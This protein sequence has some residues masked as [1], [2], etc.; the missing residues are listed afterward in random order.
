METGKVATAATASLV[1]IFSPVWLL[2]AIIAVFIIIDFVIG[3]IVSIRIKKQGFI[4]EKAYKT[5][6]KLGGA[7]IVIILSHLLDTVVIPVID[8][9]LANI[10]TGIFCGFEL[11]SILSN[12]A[13]LSNHPVF[14]IIKKWAKSE[15]ANKIEALKDFEQEVDKTVDS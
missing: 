3:L 12:F 2:A 15:I 1:S 7:M 9:H 10:F 14:R 8:L 11:W 4:T 5:G 6:W 13:I